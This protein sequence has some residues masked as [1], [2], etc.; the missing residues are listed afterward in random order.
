MFSVFRVPA[1]AAREHRNTLNTKNTDR[2]NGQVAMALAITRVI[3]AGPTS[4]IGDASARLHVS[5]VTFWTT[6]CR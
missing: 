1:R 4:M 3:I 6:A 5:A 2:M